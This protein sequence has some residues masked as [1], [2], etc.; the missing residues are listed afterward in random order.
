MKLRFLGK[1]STPDDSPTLYATDRDSYVIQG[2]IVTD[3][4]ILARFTVPDDE[5]IVEIP[6]TLL[7]HLGLDG[8]NDAVTNIVPP[9]VGVT[10]NGHYIIQGKRVTDAEV[11]SQMN[12][13]GHET[14]VLVTK[15]DVLTL[16]TVG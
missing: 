14:C 10:E 3:P 6:A 15:S 7:D 9:I 11:L 4:D 2:W 13:P 8:L 12:I 16:L 1:D 5:T